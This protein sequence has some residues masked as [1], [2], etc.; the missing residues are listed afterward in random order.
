MM[1]YLG[2]KEEDWKMKQQQSL[3]PL[4]EVGYI[5]YMMLFNL[6]KNQSFRKHD[7]W[8]MI[9]ENIVVSYIELAHEKSPPEGVLTW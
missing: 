2:K 6:V 7:E 5:D 9:P 8:N 3:L 1:K 4:G